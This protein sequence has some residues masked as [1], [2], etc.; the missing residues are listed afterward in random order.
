MDFA[1]LALIGAGMWVLQLVLGLWQFRRF[2]AHVKK[3]RPEGR[4]AIGKAKGRFS[5]GA[6]A[7]LVIDEECNIK[8]GEVM[9]GF[10]VLAGFK[11][12]DELNGMNLLSLT[13][14]NVSAA[15]LKGK[16]KQAVLSARH[17]Y[18]VFQEGKSAQKA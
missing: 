16:L 13:E 8:R 10:T 9:S 2:S 4:V 3:L 17:E 1:M 18:E 6:I 15:G 12:M 5:P 7:L 11:A 14:E